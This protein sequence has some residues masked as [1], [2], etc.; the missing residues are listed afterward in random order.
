M[1]RQIRHL[2]PRL[3]RQAWNGMIPDITSKH[4]S[5]LPVSIINGSRRR[6]IHSGTVFPGVHRDYVLRPNGLY[7]MAFS[8]DKLMSKYIPGYIP[9]RKALPEM[10]A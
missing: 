5:T 6:E 3:A 9:G 7:F 8:P 10:E 2:L 1:T 4:E